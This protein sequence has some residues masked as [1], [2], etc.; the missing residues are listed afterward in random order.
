MKM[1][2]KKLNLNRYFKFLLVGAIG[3]VINYCVF[4]SFRSRIPMDV[5]WLFGI[6]ISASI[7]Y[8]L[9]ER[10]TFSD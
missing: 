10:F 5:A 7:N 9:N 6:V 4:F 8:V 2:L 3:T 1:T